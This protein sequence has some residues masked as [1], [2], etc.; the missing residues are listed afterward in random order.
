MQ[1][2]FCFQP[3]ASNQATP[4][5]TVNGAV[6]ASVTNIVLPV[7][8]GLTE[9]TARFVN[10]GAQVIFWSYGAGASLSVANGVPML[11]N[12]VETFN[13]PAG[14]SQLAVIAAATGST[15]YVTVGDGA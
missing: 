1:T 6:T 15:L 9:C 5:G 2:Q 11:P 14:V 8:P 12:T 3:R 13:I 7:G 10:S 4:A